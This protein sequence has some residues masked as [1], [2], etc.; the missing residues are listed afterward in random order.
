MFFPRRINYFSHALNREVVEIY[1][2]TGLF[3]FAINLTYIF[4]PIFLFSLGFTLVQIMVFFMLVYTAYAL[5]V[6]PINK[7]T[8]KIGYKHAILIASVLQ[9]LYWLTLLGIKSEYKLFY[10]APLLYALQ[11]SFF[12]PSYNADIAL[13]NV[14]AQ[15]GREVGVLFSV[16]EIVA[17]LG[18]VLGGLISYQFGFLVLFTTAALLTLASVYPFFFSP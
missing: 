12:W 3:Y 8:S 7:I 4:E 17:I 16:V 11:K 10:L 18:P 14:K 15:R 1:W 5:L 2:N 13:H 6:I 9:I